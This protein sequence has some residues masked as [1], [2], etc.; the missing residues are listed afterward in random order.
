MAA[1]LAAQ[2]Q[3]CRVQA[4]VNIAVSHRRAR[5]RYARVLQFQF[6]RHVA[7]QGRDH[8]RRVPGPRIEQQQMV[9]VNLVAARIDEQGAVRVAVEGHAQ[10]IAAALHDARQLA[11]VSAAAVPVD[12][13]PVG[14]GVHGE[15]V[16]ARRLKDPRPDA[17]GR[18]V[19]TVHRDLQPPQVGRV[20]DQV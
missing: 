6:Q 13:A 9:A 7:H 14:G 15:Q 19:G 4:L 11:Q 18:A 5:E 2:V 1:L 3:P 17:V 20:A 8:A 16:R 12:V 10:V